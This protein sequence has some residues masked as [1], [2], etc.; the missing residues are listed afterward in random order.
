[1]GSTA[2]RRLISGVIVSLA[3]SGCSES[4]LRS[5]DDPAPPVRPADPVPDILVEPE[6]LDFGQLD[7]GCPGLSAD[8]TVSNVGDAVLRITSAAITGSGLVTSTDLPDEI[9]P[10]ASAIITVSYDPLQVGDV[11]AQLGV[12]SN[13]P[14]RPAAY[15]QVA[16]SAAA[17]GE[18]VDEHTQNGEGQTDVLFV[19]DN[20]GSMTEHQNKVASNIASFFVYFQS[21]QLDYHMG[22]V[23]T[24]VD[25]PDQRGRLQ[26]SP[27][28]ITPLTSNPEAALAQAVSVGE[29]DCGNESGLA[30]M[31]MALTEPNLS[32]ANAGFL[33]DDAFLSV[34][35][36]SDEPE[37][38]S[39]GS[40][41]YIDFL[42]DLK[43]DP[44]MLS[45]STIVGDRSSGCDEICGWLSVDADPGD[46]YIDVQEAYPGVFDSICTCDFSQTLTN[47]GWSSAGFQ[48]VF[49]LSQVPGDPGSIQVEIAGQPA[50]GWTYDAS[51]NAVVF[52]Q[53][54]IPEAFA[55]ITIRYTVDASCGE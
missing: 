7:A 25:C 17:L 33:R 39:P 52:G 18:A 15:V 45:V 32:T 14:D 36:L 12:L 24:D 53:S 11:T 10:G 41:Y 28:F 55:V 22:V 44:N 21:L 40:Q 46:K 48:S 4:A 54:W 50:G 43:P 37:Q 26:G 31:E 34:V 38:S 49:G 29:N 20:S 42:A 19:I 47:I 2:T 51:A 6:Q 35:L 16:A 9:A 30:A 3:L 23:T 8:V 27:T 13:D 5:F 1:M